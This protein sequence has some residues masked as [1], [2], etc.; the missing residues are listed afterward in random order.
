MPLRGLMDKKNNEVKMT[1]RKG[2]DAKEE[3]SRKLRD[4]KQFSW[5]GEAYRYT[6]YNDLRL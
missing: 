3:N 5:G 4:K 1:R 6:R 2:N